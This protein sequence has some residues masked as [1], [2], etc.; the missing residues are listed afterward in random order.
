[1]GAYVFICLTLRYIIM[2]L[3]YIDSYSSRYYRSKTRMLNT[4]SGRRWLKKFKT[5]KTLGIMT[6]SLQV[7]YLM[8]MVQIPQGSFSKNHIFCYLFIVGDKSD[9]IV[10]LNKIFRLQLFPKCFRCARL[11]QWK[12][13]IGDNS[14]LPSDATSWYRTVSPFAQ[15]I[16]CCLYEPM[17]TYHQT[18]FFGIHLKAISW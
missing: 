8:D 10:W 16:A 18:L 4:P 12:L 14:P 1:M 2:T 17:L 9:V 13:H 7:T 5:F 3:T 6:T 11:K 15:V